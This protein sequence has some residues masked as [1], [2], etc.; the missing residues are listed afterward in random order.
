MTEPRF[1]AQECAN[2]FWS[3][4]VTAHAEHMERLLRHL[5]TL[6]KS[7]VRDFGQWKPQ[8]MASAAWALGITLE[9]RREKRRGSEILGR[10]RQQA[11]ARVDQLEGKELSML[12][13]SLTE[14]DEMLAARI[15]AQAA[16]LQEKNVLSPDAIVQLSDH[17]QRVGHRVPQLQ[18]SLQELEDQT[19]RVLE[20]GGKDVA[21]KL[22]GL[23]LT[24]LGLRT[25]SLLRRLGVVDGPPPT[26][27]PGEM[28]A[29][30]QVLCLVSYSLQLGQESWAE[31][32]RIVASGSAV[33]EGVPLQAVS[34]RF[35][36]HRDA[37]F[38]ALSSVLSTLGLSSDDRGT[39]SARGAEITGQLR[40]HVTH[41]PCLSC[42]WALVQFRDLCPNVQLQVTFDST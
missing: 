25:S 18:Q 30:G 37:E 3:L 13:S 7:A 23:G 29:F 10:L 26:D 38:I 32:G 2:V 17:L 15:A 36:R 16:R 1:G 31:T 24:S 41:T 22:Q 4:A 20:G 28:A 6:P 35:S 39:C 27:D 14:E 40:L 5:E 12:S 42:V 34:L 8:E 19:F 11:V 9:R 21:E 33:P